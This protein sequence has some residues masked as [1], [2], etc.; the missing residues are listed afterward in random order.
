MSNVSPWHQAGPEQLARPGHD[1][2]TCK[3]CA[4]AT[5][6]AYLAGQAAARAAAA[7]LEP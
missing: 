5:S 4:A 1:P 6:P 7:E 3:H 2:A